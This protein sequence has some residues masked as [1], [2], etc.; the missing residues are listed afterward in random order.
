MIKLAWPGYHDQVGI[1]CE[2]FVLCAQWKTA[3]LKGKASLQSVKVGLPL[4]LIVVDL[5]GPLPESRDG[6]SYIL[7]IVDNFT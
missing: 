3:P 4:Q 5:L 6:N 1:Y 7:V 2:T